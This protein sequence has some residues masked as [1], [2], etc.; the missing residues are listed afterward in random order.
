MS[1]TDAV[2][3]VLSHFVDFGGR[4]SRSEYWWWTGALFLAY[5]LAGLLVIVEPTIGLLLSAIL[6]FGAFIPN[7]AVT[8]R[9]LHDV[10]RTGWWLLLHFIPFGSLVILIFTLLDTER[11]MNRWGAPAVGSSYVDLRTWATVP[12][13]PP[14]G[15]GQAPTSAPGAV[16]SPPESITKVFTGPTTE[17]AEAA[18]RADLAIAAASGY[19]PGGQR[20]DTSQPQPTLVVE[21]GPQGPGSA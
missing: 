9:R 12:A 2:T 7:L 16:V 14:P 13:G 10:G 1:P 19:Y 6:L 17:S 8:V 4:A 3:R 5:V 20:W 21:Y 15:W 18:S 11:G